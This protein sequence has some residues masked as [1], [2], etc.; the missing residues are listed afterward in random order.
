MKDKPNLDTNNPLPENKS[1]IDGS[2]PEQKPREYENLMDFIHTITPEAQRSSLYEE[3]FTH[4]SFINNNINCRDYDRLEFLGDGVLDLIV[5][6]L[7][8]KAHKKYKSGQLS[9]LRAS[10]VEG[11]NLTEIAIKLGFAPYVRFDKGERNNA[12]Y[13]GH[14]FEDVFEAFIGALYLDLGFDYVYKFVE[15]TMESYVTLAETAGV[16]DWVSELYDEI[17]KEFKTLVEFEIVKE[18]GTNTD[19]AFEAVAKVNGIVLG[20]GVGHNKKQAKTEAAK[21]ALLS[22]QRSK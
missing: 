12:Q 5:G 14:V 9:K 21:E 16:R 2:F 22:R 17:Q 4:A 7:V 6:D 19:K 15:K 11:H 20:T 1:P 8:F 3:A 18:S 13:H 10:I